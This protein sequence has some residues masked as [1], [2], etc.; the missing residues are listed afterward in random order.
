MTGVRVRWP[1]GAA[2]A[3]V[4]VSASLFGS[5]RG[6]PDFSPPGAARL[7]YDRAED[8]AR[9]EVDAAARRYGA[10][11]LEAIS[12]TDALIRALLRNGRGW[13]PSTLTLALHTLDAKERRLGQGHADLVGSLTNAGDALVAAAE[14]DKAVALLQRALALQ[15]QAGGPIADVLDRLGFAF[16]AASRYDEALRVLARSQVAR[17]QSPVSMTDLART[18]EL[19]GGAAQAAGSYDRAGP[20]V[21]RADDLRRQGDSTDPAFVDTLNL[22]A[23]QL[24]F[25]GDLPGSKRASEQAVE[26]GKRVLRPTHPLLLEAMRYLAGTLTDLGDLGQSHDIRVL[27]LQSAESRV[28]RRPFRDSRVSQ[29]P[30]DRRTAAGP[31]L[32]RAKPLRARAESRGGQVRPEPRPG[33]HASAEPGHGQR[34]LG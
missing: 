9:A 15:Q 31:V 10:E 12:A 27:A 23:Q 30:R 25:E 8:A 29:Q 24:W 17:E 14:Y 21:R 19:V 28:R 1:V 33:R 6:I 11:S 32:Q 22:V 16:T 26:L 7:Q 18:L 2:I 20:A 13:S 4:L 3:A 5:S 34:Q